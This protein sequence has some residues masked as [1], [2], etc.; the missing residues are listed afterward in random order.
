MENRGNGQEK[1]LS[2]KNTGNLDIFQNTENLFAQAMN[3]QIL[4]FKDIAIFA[5]KFYKFFLGN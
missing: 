5:V 3:S 1:S 2:G 4:T